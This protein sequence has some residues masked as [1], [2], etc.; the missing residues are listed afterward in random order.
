MNWL[1]SHG[2]QSE[3]RRGAVHELLSG[4]AVRQTLIGCINYYCHSGVINYGKVYHKSC[5]PLDL[6]DI[7]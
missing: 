3:V 5:V 1:A 2:E 4:H 6:H 7:Y